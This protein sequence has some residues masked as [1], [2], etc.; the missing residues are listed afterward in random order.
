MWG[1]GG[2]MLLVFC[3]GFYIFF[4]PFLPVTRHVL[5]VFLY[6][7]CRVAFS[8]LRHRVVSGVDLMPSLSWSLSLTG[9][10]LWLWWQARRG[11]ITLLFRRNPE[12]TLLWFTVCSSHQPSFHVFLAV[13]DGASF[14]HITSR[15]SL[16]PHSVFFWLIWRKIPLILKYTNNVI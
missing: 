5:F 8:F 11:I 13:T 6:T 7:S 4:L 16:P 3:V 10:L 15:T 12:L 14:L 2:G 1:E 9:L